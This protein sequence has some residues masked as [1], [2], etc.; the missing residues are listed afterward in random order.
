MNNDFDEYEYE[1]DD[2]CYECGGY[3]DNYYID[4]NGELACAC[5]GC[6]RGWYSD[7]D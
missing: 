1:D 6:V 3:G 7:W 4:E 2:Y 5:D